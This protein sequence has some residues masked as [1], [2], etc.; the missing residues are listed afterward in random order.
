MRP[1]IPVSRYMQMS[2]KIDDVSNAPCLQSC[3]PPILCRTTFTANLYVYNFRR[4]EWMGW[5]ELVACEYSR[6]TRQRCKY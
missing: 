1:R 4:N 2:R 3:D 5:A 6:D